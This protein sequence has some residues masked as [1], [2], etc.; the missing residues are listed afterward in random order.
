MRIVAFSALLMLSACASV[1]DQDGSA[2]LIEATMETHDELLKVVSAALNV[3]T[4]T[5]A[6]NALTRDSELI[7]ERV[8]ARD[9]GGRRLQG[10]ELSQPEHFHLTSAAGRCVLIHTRTKVEYQLSTAK[11]RPK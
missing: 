8:T 1:A 5:I 7:I 3:A 4:V 6:A 11:C 9:A 2:V 10:R